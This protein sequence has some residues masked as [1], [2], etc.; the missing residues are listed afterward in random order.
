MTA[1]EGGARS[2]RAVVGSVLR[3]LRLLDYFERGR[4]EMTLAELVRRSGYSKT[5]TYRLLL[6]LEAAGWLERRDGSAF[7]LTIKPFQVGSVLVDSLELRQEAASVMAR[8]AVE[9]DLT[10]Y[11][12][13]PAGSHAVCLERIDS[14]RGLRI[15][16]LYVGGSQPLHLGAGPRVLL[17]YREAE[18]LPGVLAGALERRTSHTLGDPET[19]RADLAAIRERGYSISD[20]D[21]TVGVAAIGAPVHDASGSCVAA[22]SLGGLADRILPVRPEQRDGLLR[23]AAEIS[24][25][26]GHRPA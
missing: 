19:L 3:A 2:D 21:V 8:L 13:V 11:L 7:R 20:Q 1:V 26:L 18:L 16:D 10:T 23:A 5:T 24:R 6:T 25:R 4:P 9:C 15:A 12:T 22:L 17:A 14:G